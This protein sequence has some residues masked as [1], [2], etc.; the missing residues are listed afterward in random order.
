MNDP[1]LIFSKKHF[2]S[3]RKGHFFT[4]PVKV[5]V[6]E[7]TSPNKNQFVQQLFYRETRGQ[8]DHLIF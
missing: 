2:K 1:L 8:F 6:F 7:L 5:N 3:I 4:L